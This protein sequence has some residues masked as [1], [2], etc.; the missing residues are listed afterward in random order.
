MTPQLNDVLCRVEGAAP[1]GKIMRAHWMPAC[2]IEEVAEPDGAPVRARLL[3]ENL[4]VFRGTDGRVGA[5][6]EQCPHRRA[7]LYFGR[8]EEGGLRCLYHGWK[9]DVEGNVLD[10]AC[11]P[12]AERVCRQAKHRSYPVREAGGFVWVW[13]GDPEAPSD[14]DMPAWAPTPDTRISIVKMHVDCNWAQ[15]LEG[16]IDSAHSSS[17]HSTNMPSAADVDGSTATDEAWFRPTVDKAPRIESEVTSYGFRYAAIRRPLVNEETHQY[18][19]STLFVAPFTVLIPPNDQYNLAQML[20]PI[21]DVN[22]M[23]YWIAWHETKGIEQ[24]AWR[25]FCA[26]RVGVDLDANYRKLRNASND[27]MQDREAMKNGDFTGITGIPA[28]DMAMWESMGPIADRSHDMLGSSDLAIV[29]FRRQMLA[30]AKAVEAGKP[31]IGTAQP[32]IPHV[33]LRSFEGVIPKTVD[34]KTL[35]ARR[36]QEKREIVVENV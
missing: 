30:A 2:M 17:L 32:R 15:V 13:M 16:S 1:M 34:W 19:R 6:E 23:F 20:V 36:Y 3:G 35:D 28:Q 14:F 33:K 11:E 29:R 10:M 8:N 5:L 18:V 27:Y 21:D 7:S 24:E 25:R 22:C 26:A 12:S 9:F 31:A 4:V